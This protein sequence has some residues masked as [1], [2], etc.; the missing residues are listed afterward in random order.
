MVLMEG[1]VLCDPGPTVRGKHTH[2]Q[3]RE[4]QEREERINQGCGFLGKVYDNV[5]LADFISLVVNL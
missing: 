4:R 1:F 3:E 5:F 2:T